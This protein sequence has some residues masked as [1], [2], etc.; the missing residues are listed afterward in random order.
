MTKVARMYHES[1]VRQVDI[2]Q[3]LHLSQAKVSRLL[4]QAVAAGV[5]RTIVDVPSGLRPDLEEAV[6][7]KYGLAEV[8]VADVDGDERDV[9]SGIGA[10]AAG[11]LESTLSGGERIGISSWSQTLLTTVDRLRPFR[12]QTADEVVQLLGG[13]GQP[14]VQ[15][16]AARLVND[17]AHRLGAEPIYLQAPA[18]VATEQIRDSLLS[19][20]SLAQVTRRWDHL[21]MALVGI[22]SIE[23]SPLLASSGNALPEAELDLLRAEGAVG[24]ICHHWFAADGEPIRGDLASRVVS[25]PIDTFLAIPRRVALAGGPRK[26]EAIRS[27][28]LGSWVNVLVTDLA[29]AEALL[30]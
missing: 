11:M 19:D 25:A 6:E 24:D 7:Q 5:V 16:L 30:S 8:V 10:A 21:T 22:G 20:P 26:V 4:K 15:A 27:A 14:Q 2:A 23:P 28:L 12:A 1:G 9:L 17:L 3:A 13:V 18:V 29:T